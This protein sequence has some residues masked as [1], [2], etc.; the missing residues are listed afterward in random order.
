MP[1][2]PVGCLLWRNSLRSSLGQPKLPLRRRPSTDEHEI[3]PA[4]P[5]SE[6]PRSLPSRVAD[7]RTS[8]PARA[9]E[10][11]VRSPLRSSSSRTSEPSTRPAPEG[12][13]HAPLLALRCA[14]LRTPKPPPPSCLH[15]RSG[16]SILR[17]SRPPEPGESSPNLKIR[18]G[19]VGRSQPPSELDRVALRRR[20]LLTPHERR[21]PAVVGP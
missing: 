7:T 1:Q 15:L 11:P 6:R 19:L 3:T 4:P 2:P 9:P 8:F 21:F 10:V 13:A 20:L 14:V 5:A 12:T 16:S 17:A 18:V